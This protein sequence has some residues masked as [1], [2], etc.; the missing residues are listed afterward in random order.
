MAKT[1]QIQSKATIKIQ[2]R[3]KKFLTKNQ[4]FGP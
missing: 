3:R 1:L 4:F 2:F